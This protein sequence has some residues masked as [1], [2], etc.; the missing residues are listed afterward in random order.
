[1]YYPQQRR[2]NAKYQLVYDYGNG[3]VS[4]YEAFDEQD[5]IRE[6]KYRIQHDNIYPV[7]FRSHKSGQTEEKRVGY[8]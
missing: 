8:Q 1:M 5:A 3:P 6:K 4:I 7:I 2:A